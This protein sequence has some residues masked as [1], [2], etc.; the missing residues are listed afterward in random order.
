MGRSMNHGLVARICSPEQ[1]R[2]L[3]D[4][5]LGRSISTVDD[6][7]M[8]DGGACDEGASVIRLKWADIFN[9]ECG[10]DQRSA[11]AVADVDFRRVD[12]LICCS[13]RH[14]LMRVVFELSQSL[15]G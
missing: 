3:F 12:E 1:K 10:T 8:D 9:D 7:T 13:L 4:V 5:Q 11:L 6:S 14:P 2:S 15:S